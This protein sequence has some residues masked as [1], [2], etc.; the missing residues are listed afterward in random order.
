MLVSGL[1]VPGVTLTGQKSSSSVPMKTL[2]E[3]GL[4]TFSSRNS[5]MVP[6]SGLTLLTISLATQPR[7]TAWYCRLPV[8]G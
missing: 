7:V 8:S 1:L 6:W 5:P 4:L 2:A 3:R